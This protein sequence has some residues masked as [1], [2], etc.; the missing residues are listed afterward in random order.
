MNSIDGFYDNKK[1]NKNRC[2]EKF[3]ENYVSLKKINL[4]KIKKKN[5]NFDFGVY[6]LLKNYWRKKRAWSI[7]LRSKYHHVDDKEEKNKKNKI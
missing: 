7:K 2:N 5:N 6:P 3:N 4:R 1:Y